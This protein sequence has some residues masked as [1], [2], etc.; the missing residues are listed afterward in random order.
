MKYSLLYFL[1]SFAYCA[2]VYGQCPPDDIL[3]LSQQEIDDFAVTYPNCTEIEGDVEIGMFGMSTDIQNLQALNQITSIEGNLRIDSNDD[4]ISLGG[5]DNLS[6]IGATLSI[7][8]SALENLSGLEAVTTI[9]GD[10]RVQFNTDLADLNG[11][12]NLSTVGGD[13]SFSNNNA[14][15]N[16]NGLQQLNSIGGELRLF[17]NNALTDLTGL[18]GLSSI[19]GNFIIQFN[20]GITSLNGLN[21]TSMIGGNLVVQFNGALTSLEALAS[22]TEIGGYLDI[23]NNAMLIALT[24][25]DNIDHTSIT[26]LRLFDNPNLA[27]CG[28]LSICNYLENMG[29]YDIYGNASGC[30]SAEETGCLVSTVAPERS[31]FSVFPVPARHQVHLQFKEEVSSVG[32]SII[33]VSGR[34]MY[35]QIVDVSGAIP[36]TFELGAY[37]PGVY[38]L[39]VNNGERLTTERFVKQ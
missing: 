15:N 38:F 25:L 14:I 20:S 9:G 6:A 3:F 23:D 18:E 7:A 31:S 33:S 34:V 37:P 13:F 32:V 19:E 5:L 35:Q 21:N 24:G 26:D 1:I 8:Y 27:V 39:S 36:L 17:S 16:L 12:G 4:L 10:L 29:T 28:V 11:L 2:N 22:L 30:N